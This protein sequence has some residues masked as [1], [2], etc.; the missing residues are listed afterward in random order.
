[1]KNTEHTEHIEKELFQM[2]EV[3][4]A[5]G[6]TRKILLNYEE[7]GL[8]TPALKNEH[9]GYRYYSA[10]NL[11][12]IRLIRTLQNLGLSLPEIHSYFDN[13]VI[14]EDEI[15]R[16]ILLRNQLDQYIAELRLRQAASQPPEIH[17][18]TLP[19]FT[20]FCRDF[21]GADLAQKT[22]ELRNTYIDTVKNYKI[23]IHNKMCVQVP[24]ISEDSGT[25]IVPVAPGSKGASIRIFPQ[26]TAICIYYRGAYENFPKVHAQ[27][28]DYARTHDMVPHGFFRNIY[29]EGPPTHG[30][31]KDAYITQIALPIKFVGQF[32]N[33]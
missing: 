16:L 4:K 11:V 23:D 22:A 18:V 1:M 6:L 30:T 24:V 32:N 7:L 17:H 29:M 28:L 3:T 33:Q 10:D 20:A 13:T 12:H 14:L 27:L 21:S 2:G 9:N 15:D 5:L 26:T 19:E 31:N 8:L 25:Y